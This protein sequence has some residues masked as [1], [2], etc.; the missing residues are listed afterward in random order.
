MRMLYKQIRL[1]SFSL[2]YT[3]GVCANCTDTSPRM[4]GS[5]LAG[6][7][8]FDGGDVNWGAC[9]VEGDLQARSNI[10]LNSFR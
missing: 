1:L 7:G 8:S 3:K 4:R 6:T 10:P 5:S 9:I 2:V